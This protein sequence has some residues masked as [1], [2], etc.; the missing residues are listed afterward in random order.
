MV[1]PIAIIGT[2][3]TK[4]QEVAYV[5]DSIQPAGTVPDHRSGSAG[6]SRPSP[7]ISPARRWLRAGGADLP[8]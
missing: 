7:P 5:R 2:L 3:D 8:S 4:G 6:T 1:K